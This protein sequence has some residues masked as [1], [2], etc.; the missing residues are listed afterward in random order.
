MVQGNNRF[1]VHFIKR[2]TCTVIKQINAHDQHLHMYNRDS[3][4][5]VL[6]RMYSEIEES[7][8][9]CERVSSCSS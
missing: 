3:S 2:Y 1:N 4:P 5:I 7:T 8:A 9:R 6:T